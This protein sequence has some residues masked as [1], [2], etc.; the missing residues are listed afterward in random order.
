VNKQTK[1]IS[2][3]EDNYKSV[4]ENAVEGMFRADADGRFISA[5]AAFAR[6]H[7]FDRPDDLIKINLNFGNIYAD[8]KERKRIN[9]LLRDKGKV[10]NL[11]T[12]MHTRDGSARWVRMN[13][14]AE[15][16]NNGS[17]LY[18]EGTLEDITEKK[19]AED[20]YWNI[21]F[22]AT[23]GIFQVT[24]EGRLL[25]ANPALV[26]LHGFDSLEELSENCMDVGKQLHVNVKTWYEYL[27]M[28]GKNGHVH[29]HLWSMYRK[30]GS[31]AWFLINARAVC[32][33]AGQVLYHEG[34]VQD[35]TEKKNMVDQILMQRD[36]ALKLAQTGDVGEGLTLILETAV[37][38]SGM[39]SGGIWLKKHGGEDLE[40][41]S[42]IGLSPKME[43]KVR[44]IAAGSSP[45]KRMMNEKHILIIPSSESMPTSSEEGY[46]YSA[47]IPILHD[48]RVIASFNLF[49]RVKETIS[50]QA[51]ISLDFLAG[52]LGNIIVRIEVQQKLEQ[53]IKTRTEAEKA[54]YTERQG[55]EEANIALK[56]LLRQREKD[57]E[58]LEQRFVSNVNELVLPYV[59]KLKKNRLDGLQR[60]TL[61]LIETNLRE[62][63]SPFR[64]NVRNFNLT[65]RQLEIVS[66]IKQGRTTKEI[67]EL[68]SATKDAIDKQ[69]FIIRK[70]LGVNNDKTNL[71]SLLLS[72]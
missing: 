17:I 6:M 5:N 61:G 1:D 22:N 48:G 13:I 9:K 46:K 51:I 33:E 2:K 15:K 4:Y 52:Q 20:K 63:L 18:Y 32:D 64:Y 57:K 28:I 8:S 53:E 11:E 49:S 44:V 56:V 69:R 50:E 62:I 14:R 72:L 47:T 25:N 43:K 10:L 66:L 38:A 40:L 34:T 67:A 41:T 55:L 16:D 19:Q 58:E 68:L 23:E 26:R 3:K 39:E 35:I 71:R 24:P 54:L 60:T 12:Q 31:I 37:K 70:K 21:F 27:E 29:D 30:D 65:P 59:E 36:L 45:W 42:S 7:G